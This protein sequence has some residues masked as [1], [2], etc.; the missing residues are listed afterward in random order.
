[1]GPKAMKITHKISL[2]FLMTALLLTGI[3]VPI[4]Y[5]TAKDSL[6][7]AIFAHL[8]TT[9]KSRAEHVKTSL[10]DQKHEAELIAESSWLE[11]AMEAINNNPAG[12]PELIEKMISEL[13]E[14]AHPE[15]GLYEVF[16][17][18]PDGKIIA[19]SNRSRIGLNRST[20]AYFLEGRNK[21]YVKDAY[22]SET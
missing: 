7:K 17:L 16:V 21:T 9:A 1:M 12:S 3:T 22:Y 15:Q 13:E 20:D 6:Q 5:W 14:C 8:R 18:N 10:E 19:S 11:D 4:F 2:S